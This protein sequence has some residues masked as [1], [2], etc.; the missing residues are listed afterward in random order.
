M[1]SLREIYTDSI[2]GENEAVNRIL[3]PQTS[4]VQYKGDITRLWYINEE[5][6]LGNLFLNKNIGECKQCF[7]RCG[8]IDEYE[9]KKYDARILDW[10]T[11]HLL[12]ATLSDNIPLMQRYASL[13]HTHY[14]WMVER[15]HSTLTYAIQQVIK[16]DWEKLRWCLDIMSAKKPATNKGILPDRKFFEGMIARDRVMITEAILELLEAKTHKRRNKNAGIAQEYISTPALGYTK[17]AWLKG[18]E[19]E[20]DH[21]LIPKELLPYNPLEKYED[22]YAFLKEI[23]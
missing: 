12:H 16:E 6:A 9:I 22:K 18:I 1:L 8:R 2:R 10:G 20:I 13:S 23:G 21:P 5:Q 19:I 15:G 11:N 4:S 17:L 14:A 7:Y 3:S